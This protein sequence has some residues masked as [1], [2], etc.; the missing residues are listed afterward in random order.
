MFNAVLCNTKNY[1]GVFVC[2]YLDGNRSVVKLND[3]YVKNT[4]GE[5]FDNEDVVW[6]ITVRKDLLDELNEILQ[7][8]N[9]GKVI[10]YENLVSKERHISFC[11]NGFNITSTFREIIVTNGKYPVFSISKDHDDVLERFLTF[12]LR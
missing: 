4:G 9:I 6:S 11:F 8:F 12:V 7:G 5:N 1:P 10:R 2:C 3:M